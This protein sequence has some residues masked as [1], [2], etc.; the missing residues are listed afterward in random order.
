[1]SA[2]Y[3]DTPLAP[4][5]E[6][7]FD[8]ILTDVSARLAPYTAK[9]DE[10]DRDNKLSEAQKVAAK[11]RFTKACGPLALIYGICTSAHSNSTKRNVV[12]TVQSVDSALSAYVPK[13]EALLKLFKASGGRPSGSSSL[14][15]GQPSDETKRVSAYRRAVFLRDLF[16]KIS[17]EGDKKAAQRYLNPQQM[18]IWTSLHRKNGLVQ[19]CHIIPYSMG[20]Y[21]HREAWKMLEALVGFG[22]MDKYGAANIN[23]IS[24]GMLLSSFWHDQT[25]SLDASFEKTDVLH[26]YRL[27]YTP[28]TKYDPDRPPAFADWSTPSPFAS[29]VP[30]PQLMAMH[31]HLWKV[32]HAHAAGEAALLDIMRGPDDEGL[33]LPPSAEA[34]EEGAEEAFRAL[35]WRLGLLQLQEGVPC[36]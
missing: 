13:F 32:T 19:A 10:I 29:G 3:D 18:G 12:Y 36:S 26:K 17:G 14:D 1:M 21:E 20:K 24:N 4:W 15:T 27:A 30:D 2:V 6:T 16:C 25:G 28:E 8:T 11:Q 7:T 33:G 23:Q 34:A 9:L 31:Y 35:E 22:L 5:E